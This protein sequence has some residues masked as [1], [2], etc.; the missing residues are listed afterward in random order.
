MRVRPRHFILLFLGM[1][2][3]NPTWAREALQ[4]LKLV[5]GEVKVLEF[6]N[7]TR[8]A[9]GD[10][11]IINYRT[12]DN[13][14]ILL[15]ANSAGT[16]NVHIWQ[17]G[18]RE[19]VLNVVVS[20]RNTE[21][22]LDMAKTLISHINGL[23]VK[24]KDDRLVFF[25]GIPEEDQE[26]VDSLVKLFPSGVNLTRS[27]GFLDREMVRLDV[28]IIET[29]KDNAKQ[30]GIRWDTS[31]SGPAIGIHKA[32]SQNGSFGIVSSNDNGIAEE[33]RES[34]NESGN[35]LDYH[36]YKY[37]G[38]TSGLSSTIDL[39]A[40]TGKAEMLAAP[41]LVARSGESAH[42]QSGGNYPI[43]VRG[44]N[45]EVTVGFQEYGIILDIEPMVMGGQIK[46]RIEAEVSSIDFGVQ[47]LNVP[48]LIRRKAD[49]VVNVNAGDTVVISGL[50]AGN[51]SRQVN[52]MPFLGD[53][54][55][56]G[57]LFRSTQNRIN[58]K[59]LLIAVTPYIISAN[60]DK[61]QALELELNERINSFNETNPLNAVLLD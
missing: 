47:V 61:D 16:T 15:V 38:I 17:L 25:G 10:G 33:I 22:D 5:K 51:T 19:S 57:A 32:F 34:L 2:A 21:T 40:E 9:S 50:T 39:M 49:T 1:L 12:L 26:R 45:G 52:K 30:L 44:Q 29:S 6:E 36:F 23:R 37:F 41:K 14:Q 31:A 28:R 42:F 58:Q 8:V 7:I 48:G 46:T 18:G 54:P 35:G 13:G 55:V 53:L 60:D 24:Q 11:E 3:I 4:S 56:V 20:D 59:E 27:T 43:P